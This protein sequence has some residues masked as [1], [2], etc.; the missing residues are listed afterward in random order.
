VSSQKSPSTQRFNDEV[1]HITTLWES[2]AF[3]G[4]YAVEYAYWK[5][6]LRNG[7]VLSVVSLLSA[8]G[9]T[10]TA[11][12]IFRVTARLLWPQV[13]TFSYLAMEMGYMARYFPDSR[14]SLVAEVLCPEVA[15]PFWK[16]KCAIYNQ[17][18]DKIDIRAVVAAARS[19]QKGDAT[20]L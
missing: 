12:P 19:K 18:K 17:K 20:V 13:V 1:S 16:E 11:A 3:P 6:I 10:K 4:P 2:K 9:P 7:A 5:N 15:D 14:R 8:W